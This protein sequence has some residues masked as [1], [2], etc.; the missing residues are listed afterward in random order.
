MILFKS[1]YV[2]ILDERGD[3]SRAKHWEHHLSKKTLGILQVEG[4]DSTPQV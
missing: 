1:R 3:I 4:C 2:D